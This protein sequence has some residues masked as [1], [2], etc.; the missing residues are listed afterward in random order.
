MQS[1]G[2]SFGEDVVLDS[3][4]KTYLDENKILN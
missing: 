3:F 2:K 4:L 1:D